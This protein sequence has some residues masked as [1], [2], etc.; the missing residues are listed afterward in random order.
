MD[1]D[2]VILP[3]PKAIH[4]GSSINLINFILIRQIRVEND[5]QAKV[6]IVVKSVQLSI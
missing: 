1:D 6:D 3:V 4:N 5:F 2:T